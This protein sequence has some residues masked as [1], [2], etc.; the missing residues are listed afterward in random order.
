MS[1]SCNRAILAFFLFLLLLSPP[2]LSGQG[3]GVETL[4]ILGISVEANR[5][6]TGTDN[7]AIIANTGLTVGEEIQVPGERIRQ[8]MQRLWALKIFSDIRITVEQRLE[9]GI[10]L[11]ITVTEYPRLGSLVFEGNDELDEDDLRSAAGAVNGQILT[12]D[13]LRRMA[14]SVRQKYEKEGMLLTTVVPETTSA[15]G[16][17]PNEVTL[18]LR[19][20]EGPQVSIDSITLT[21]T[22]AFPADDVESQME[23]TEEESWWFF[24]NAD[25][26]PDKYRQDK[27]KIISFYRRNGYLDAEI[28]SDSSWYSADREKISLRLNI[29]EGEQ[30]FVRNIVWEGNAVYPAPMLASRL[31]FSTGDI[32]DGERFEGNLRGNAEQTDVASLYLDNGYLT[33]GLD[34]EI[35]RVGP[36]SVDIMIRIYE[37]NQYRIGRVD[38]RGNTKTEDQVIRRELFTRPGDY[39]NRSRIIRSLRQLSQLN[40]FNPENLR[41]DYRLNDDNETVNLIYDVEEKSSDNV[42]ASVGYSDAFGVTGALGF[43]ITN[44]SLSHPLQGGAG[45][46]FNFEWQF[47]EGSRYRTLSLGF[48]EPWL[49]G[50]PTT[51]GLNIFDTR[52]VYVY[53]LRQTG[54]S[55]RFGRRLDWPDNYFRIDWNLRFQ[56]NDVQDNGGNILIQ[57]GKTQQFSVRMTVSRNSTDSPIFPTEGSNVALSAEVAGGALLPGNVDYHK[58]SFGADWYT[59]L[60]GIE[61]VSLAASTILGYL[62]GLTRIPNIPPIEYYYMGGTGVGYVST[63][64]LRGYEDRSIGPRDRIGQVIGGRVMVKYGLELRYAVT[65]N[66]IP[67]YLLTFAEAGNVWLSFTDADIFDLKRGYGFGARVLINPLGMVGADYAYGADDVMPLNG[68]PDGW[69]FHF[70]FGKGF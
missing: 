10:Y 63:T 44:F 14:L 25:F 9:N 21:G 17:K 40:Y 7:D 2:E 36:D 65:L 13:D 32:F 38:L 8:A 53:D 26:D 11:L 22:V 24:S 35:R 49:Y 66:P 18:T 19:I 51:F 67:I 42:N 61:Q 12:P 27:E 41:P 47:G 34:P 70:Q 20:D 46:I 55:V 28:V 39:F 23:D 45:Q 62:D 69:R 1:L 58:W 57:T 30:Y 48:T 52:Q 6:G 60:F 50:S 54:V 16:G 43:T 68:R 33:F 56:H 5:S 15:A 64:Q 3:T 31:Q 59:R 4:K 37:R 29:H